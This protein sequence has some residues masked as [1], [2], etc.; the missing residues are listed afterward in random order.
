[1]N[2]TQVFAAAYR[3]TITHSNS[4]AE[5]VIDLKEREAGLTITEMKCGHACNMYQ[6]L[7][8]TVGKVE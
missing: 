4:W 2:E 5:H 1:M 8:H 6:Y 3:D 7:G